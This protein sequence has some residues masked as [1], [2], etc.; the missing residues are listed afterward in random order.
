MDSDLYRSHPDWVLSA[1]PVP[2]QLARHQ[3]V[4]DLTR[5]EV[6]DY[7]FER[8]DALLSEYPIT[9]LKWDMNRDLTQPG[10]QDGRAVGH[11]QILA[12]YDLLR[13]VRNAHPTVEI[14]SCSSGGGRADFGVLA[15]TDRIWTSDSNDALDRLRIQR[16]FSFFFPAEFMGAHVG[17]HECHVTGRKISLATRA[18]VSLFGDMGIEA[19]LL[20]FSDEERTQLRDAV[21]LHK[22]HRELIF[23]GD[24]FRLDMEVFENGFGIVSQNK[25]N[26]LF[27]YALLSMPPHSTP[28]RMH[29]RGLAPDA[30]YDVNVIW[31]LEPYSYSES[32][33]DVIDSM[34]VS[35][36]ALMGAG[37]QLP[38][39]K[40]ESLLVFHLVQVS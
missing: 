7:L 4:L 1:A 12:Y 21:A 31:P 38:I 26:A 2:L 32:I 18:G 36:D 13:R 35:G 8:L 3:L 17:P 22:K 23:S 39:Q 5:P 11:Y 27:S 24:L 19:N 10:G 9:Y 30:L 20:E 29:F 15:H 14:E 37:I 16:G 34:P 40:P 28:G 33:L 25:R 6:G